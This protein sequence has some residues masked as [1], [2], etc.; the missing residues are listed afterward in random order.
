[1]KLDYSL[2]SCTK[3]NSK[4]IKDLNTRSER[5]NYIEE[6]VSTTLMHLD[7]RERFMNLTPK[8]R[9]V[10]AK[11]GLHQTKKFLQSK[12]NIQ[13]NQKATNQMGD[14]CKQL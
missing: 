4:W 13:Q 9:E 7:H 14:I 5:I 1:M 8:I 11:M 3:I 12:R 10:K 2:S 6:N